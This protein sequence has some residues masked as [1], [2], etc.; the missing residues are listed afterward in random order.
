ME[1]LLRTTSLGNLLTCE[2]T[3]AGAQFDEAAVIDAREA[4]ERIASAVA[5]ILAG[6]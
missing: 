4:T 1:A 3:A 5:A 6:E 2:F